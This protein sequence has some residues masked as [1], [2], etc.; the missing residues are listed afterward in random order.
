MRDM[1]ECRI[2]EGSAEVP[3][4]RKARLHRVP[5]GPEFARKPSFHIERELG[6][7]AQNRATFTRAYGAEQ[8]KRKGCF[9]GPWRDRLRGCYLLLSRFSRSFWARR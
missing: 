8:A 5:E 7:T 1:V 6:F 3:E 2:S 9:L 4:G